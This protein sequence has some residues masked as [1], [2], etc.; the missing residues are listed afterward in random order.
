MQCGFCTPG[1]V[2]ATVDLLEREPGAL[3]RRDPRGAL[4]QP[5]PLHGLRRRSSTP[6]GRRPRRE[7]DER[8][9]ARSPAGSA[10]ASPRPDGAA[11]GEGGVRLLERPP[12][13][14]DA[15][16]PHAAQPPCARP[17]RR[18]R[19]RAGADDARRPRRAHARGRARAQKTYGLEFPDQPVL[20]IDRVR[21]YGEPVALVAAEHP[22]QARRAAEA[23]PSSTSSSSRSS[24]WSARPSWSRSTRT[25]RRWA[26]ATA[27][28]R[29]RTSFATS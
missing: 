24:T 6:F 18:D 25:G 16:G 15:L 13:G 26:T 14:G 20:A 9:S 29:A 3:R 19:H 27:T 10:T 5:L 8:P 1:L 4:R 28:T 11:E 12:G 22:E 7:R 21:Y 23:I 2:V 17:H